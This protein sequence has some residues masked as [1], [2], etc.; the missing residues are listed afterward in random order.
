MSIKLVPTKVFKSQEHLDRKSKAILRGQQDGHLYWFAGVPVA[1]NLMLYME[2]LAKAMPHVT[3]HPRVTDNAES[4]TK[5]YAVMDNNPYALGSVGYGDI[6]LSKNGSG[7]PWVCSRR[8]ANGKF[9][10]HRDQHKMVAPKD[11]KKAVKEA[12]KYLVPY[13]NEEL[14][15]F[16]YDEV[17]DEAVKHVN[18]SSRKAHDLCQ[19]YTRSWGVHANFMEEMKHLKGLGVRFATEFF[20]DAMMHIDEA[21]AEWDEVRRYAPAMTFVRVEEGEYPRVHVI[22]GSANMRQEARFKTNTTE[23]CY[24]VDDLPEEI[25]GKVAVLQILGNEQYAVRVGYK[26]SNN[27]FWIERDLNNEPR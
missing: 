24:S 4:I 12:R 11:I 1:Y 19:K 14:I 7:S 9:S 16:M 21:Y 17:R 10:P 23:T 5:F 15:H 20:A 27:I 13:T 3:F 18:Q 25:A 8:I 26:Y 22:R 2:E 6:S